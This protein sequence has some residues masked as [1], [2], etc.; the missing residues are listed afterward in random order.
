M[1][2]SIVIPAYNEAHRLPG[3]LAAVAAYL[4]RERLEA[5]IIVVDDGSTD[6]TVAAVSGL[7]GYALPPRVI[8]SKRN[9]GKGVSVRDGLLAAQGRHVLFMDAD[10]STPIDEQEKLLAA[11]GKG[12]DVAIGSRYLRGDS[13]KIKQ[14]WYRVWVSRVGNR[15]IRYTLLP[16][17]LD[18]QCGFKLFT[19]AAARDI[20]GRLTL[21]GYSFDVELLVIARCLGYDVREVAVDWYDAPGSRVRLVPTSIRTL[22]EVLRMC[23]AR[24]GAGRSPTRVG[25][26]AV[27]RVASVG[28]AKANPD[29]GAVPQ[30]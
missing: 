22:W 5:E 26:A 18:T 28:V 11:L 7:E 3:T 30:S 20:A 13:I 12:A 27:D 14:R 17:M 24:V 6:Q 29:A 10:H 19:N 16:G 25:G 4:E 15:V 8:A 9:R 2:L 1:D 23:A 21:A